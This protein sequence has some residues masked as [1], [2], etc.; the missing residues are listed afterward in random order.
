[1]AGAIDDGDAWEEI[2]SQDWF[3]SAQA[4]ADE[5]SFFHWELE[6]PEVFFGEDGNK[7][8]DA[9]FDAVV[10]NPPYVVVEGQIEDYLRGKYDSPQYFVDLYHVFI[11]KGIDLCSLGGQFGYIVPEPWLTQ[12]K[13]ES[14]RSVVLEDS[15]IRRITQFD[16]KVFEDATVDTIT[17]HIEDN[18]PQNT[19]IVHCENTDNGIANLETINSVPQENFAQNEYKRIEIRQ[20]AEEQNLLERITS[21]FVTI[22]DIA[23]VSIGIQAYNSS[24]HSQET[25]D[26]R[27]FH[28][29]HK[30]SENI[31][32]RFRG[33]MY[34]DIALNMMAKLG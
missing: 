23:D 9:G 8:G 20:T 25:I 14:L 28:E 4:T 34:P 31:Y 2:R 29:D 5:Q 30:K 13:T 12:E 18:T 33:K 3:A 19:E 22:D 27:A 24:K 6:Y 15:W 7:L 1:M 10:G 32:Q 21:E 26:S 17:V 16:K 11:E